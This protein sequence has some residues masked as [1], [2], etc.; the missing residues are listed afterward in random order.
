MS[1]CVGVCGSAAG[2]DDGGCSMVMLGTSIDES[3]G[4]GSSAAG[5]SVYQCA[6]FCECTCVCL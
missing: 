2:D 4:A 5:G 6:V 1:A 3:V